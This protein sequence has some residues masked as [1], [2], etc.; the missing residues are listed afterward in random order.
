[1]AVTE[2]QHRVYEALRRVPRGRVTTYKA[3][4]DFL[5]CGSCRAIGQALRRNPFAPK[6]P[7]H[8]VIASDLRIGGFAGAT[9]GAEIARKRRLLA[10]EGVRFRNER[11]AEPRRCLA[12]LSL[13]PAACG[14]VL[15]GAGVPR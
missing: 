2:F 12:D 10:S 1:M 9:S 13:A 3:L 4:A 11:L 8:R 14:P 15:R 6:V 7:C 5:G